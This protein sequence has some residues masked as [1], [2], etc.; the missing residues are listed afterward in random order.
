MQNET[1]K[2]KPDDVIVFKRLDRDTADEAV[3]VVRQ[4]LLSRVVSGQ[5]LCLVHVTPSQFDVLMDFVDQ[6]STTY[7]RPRRDSRV[8]GRKR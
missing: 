6:M 3:G 1:Y 5:D 4:L 7:A 2:F 8:Y